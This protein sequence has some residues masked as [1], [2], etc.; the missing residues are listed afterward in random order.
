MSASMIIVLFAL[1]I[2]TSKMYL[3][4]KA[5]N[6]IQIEYQTGNRGMK[7]Y[8]LAMLPILYIKSL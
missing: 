8:I 2:A 7:F 1:Y 4:D 3:L 6:D 5:R